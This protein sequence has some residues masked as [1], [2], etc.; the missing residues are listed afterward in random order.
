VA[1]ATAL[2]TE[3][4]PVD[5]TLEVKPV[6]DGSSPSSPV[7]NDEYQNVQSAWREPQPQ[8][9]DEYLPQT[10]NLIS[11][12]A[13]LSGPVHP[14][15]FLPKDPSTVAPVPLGANMTKL[16]D[17]VVVVDSKDKHPNP[18]DV[19]YPIQQDRSTTAYKDS[20][21]TVAGPLIIDPKKQDAN[22]V[23]APAV[24]FDR[25]EYVHPMELKTPLP[26]SIPCDPSR[27]IRVNIP[28]AIPSCEDG[29]RPPILP[30]RYGCSSYLDT[31][32]EKVSPQITWDN[33]S[34]DV[35][36]FSL[37]MVE[38]GDNC[39]GTGPMYGR[40]H[41]HVNGIRASPNVNLAEG[42]SHDAR[43]LMGGKEQPNQWLEEYYSGP[44]PAPGTTGCYRFKVL[45]HRANGWCQCGYQDVLFQR[46]PV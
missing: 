39:N 11:E 19:F 45:A 40:I 23:N 3:K 18:A 6:A 46:S 42:A 4:A 16:A 37:Q 30:Q 35:V 25:P 29:S 2:P 36:E 7:V 5:G 24:V 31:S 41:W 15:E 28:A 38:M 44:C 10:G 8:K 14:D 34:E 12:Q 17:A 32:R 43:L 13:V 21:D 22:G 33:V 1:F 26:D 9:P 20:F 27:N